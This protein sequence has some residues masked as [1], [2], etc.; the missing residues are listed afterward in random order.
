MA[1]TSDWAGD[2]GVGEV[3]TEFTCPVQVPVD[4]SG[5][6]DEFL[7]DLSDQSPEDVAEEHGAPRWRFDDDG[8]TARLLL[9]NADGS[10]G[11]VTTYDRVDGTLVDGRVDGCGD[12]TPG[13]P[14]RRC[15][16]ARPA[17]RRAV[18]RDG[19]CSTPRTAGEPVFID[20]R[21]VYDYSGLV[22]RHRSIYVAPCGHVCAGSQVSPE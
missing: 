10:L 2:A 19:D 1:T 16:S 9:G 12:G 3:A 8:D 6:Q 22:K 21:A 5:A 17:R 13:R 4:L 11:S 14:D 7:P 20:D 15:P 18:A